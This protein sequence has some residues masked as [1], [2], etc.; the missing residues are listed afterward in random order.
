MK[1]C[2]EHYKPVGRR[3]PCNEVLNVKDEDFERALRLF[4]GDG[5]AE[6]IAYRNSILEQLYGRGWIRSAAP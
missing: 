5:T 4:E 6:D 3:L 2:R 1:A